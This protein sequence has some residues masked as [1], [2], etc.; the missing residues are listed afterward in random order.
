MR[1][2]VPCMHTLVYA[3]AYMLTQRPEEGVEDP[4][5]SLDTSLT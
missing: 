5:S 3:R 1:M 2:C 4:A